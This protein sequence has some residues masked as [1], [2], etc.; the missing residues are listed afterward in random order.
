MKRIAVDANLLLLLIVGRTAPKWIGQHQRLKTYTA[1]DYKM[2]VEVIAN[3]R[4][5]LVIPHCI[6]EASNLLPQGLTEPLRASMFQSL[7]AM[8]DGSEEEYVASSRAAAEVSYTRLGITD[9]A[10]LVALND[11][12]TLLTD[13][14]ELYIAASSRGSNVVNFSH[15]RM[16]K[17]Q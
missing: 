11:R 7:K 6:A 17:G 9:A 14:N 12:T 15:L 10:W 16:A 13:D 5:L 2:L 8:I 4:S 1:Q 3:A